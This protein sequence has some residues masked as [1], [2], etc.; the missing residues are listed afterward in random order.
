MD[1]VVEWVR[2]THA[3]GG[4]VREIAAPAGAKGRVAIEAQVPWSRFVESLGIPYPGTKPRLDWADAAVLTGIR[5]GRRKGLALHTAAVLE[6]EKR[7]YHQGTKRF[8][9]WDAAMRAAGIAPE[10]VRK[11][12]TWTRQEVVVAI[13]SRA[14]A[15]GSCRFQQGSRSRNIAYDLKIRSPCQAS[16]AAEGFSMVLLGSTSSGLPSKG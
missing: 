6:D 7:L 3:H 10:R 15:G 4:D 9:S 13:R 1:R 2:E 11:H 5:A 8:G 12:R 14:K 16:T